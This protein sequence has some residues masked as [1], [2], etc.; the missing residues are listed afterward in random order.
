MA[1]AAAALDMFPRSPT[2]ES[3]RNVFGQVVLRVVRRLIRKIISTWTRL[4]TSWL[5][6]L[7]MSFEN[8]SC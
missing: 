6:S 2:T 5:M 3:L 1:S 4:R 8:G 7:L